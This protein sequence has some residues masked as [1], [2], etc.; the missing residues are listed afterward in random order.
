MNPN[1]KKWI[2]LAI[3]L[4]AVPFMFSCSMP[5]ADE[6]SDACCEEAPAMLCGGCGEI[7]GSDSCCEEAPT[8]DSCGL[9]AGS[10]GCC[11]MEKGTDVKLCDCGAPA[12]SDACKE[13]CA[14]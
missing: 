3:M 13:N 6:C 2:L 10:L 7:K 14:K 8:C 12:G 11:K 9:H 5:C 1:L 4:L